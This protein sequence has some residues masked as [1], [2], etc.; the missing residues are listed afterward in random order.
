MSGDEWRASGMRGGQ[1][2]KGDGR[3]WMAGAEDRACPGWARHQCLSLVPHPSLPFSSLT[4][5][6]SAPPLPAAATVLTTTAMAWW[7]TA[8][9]SWTAPRARCVG[10]GSASRCRPSQHPRPPSTAALRRGSST[11]TTTS[12]PSSHSG[13]SACGHHG[14]GLCCSELH[15]RITACKGAP[16]SWPRVYES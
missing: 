4:R 6:P 1:G 8:W 14:V 3:R 9:T 12:P 10:R 11:G 15:A 5:A 13:P 16:R 2:E 7:T